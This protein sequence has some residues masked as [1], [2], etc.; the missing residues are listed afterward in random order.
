[1][2]LETTPLTTVTSTVRP[3]PEP[4]EVGSFVKVPS[5][6]PLPPLTTDK[7][8][9]GPSSLYPKIRPASLP[10]ISLMIILALGSTMRFSMK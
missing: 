1:M 6:K 7:P 10:N 2:T 3:V 8:V 9:T 4:P 5:V